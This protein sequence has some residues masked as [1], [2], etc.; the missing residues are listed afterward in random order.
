MATDTMLFL[1]LDIGTSGCRGVVIDQQLNVYA[2]NEVALP[3]AEGDGACREQNPE[4]WWQAVQQVLGALTVNVD[5][6]DLVGVAVD[7]TSGTLL[8]A[9][10]AGVP[11]TPALM[12]NDGR[13]IAEAERIRNVAPPESGAHGPTSALAKLLWLQSR[14]GAAGARYALTQADWI[15]GRLRGVYGL[16]DENN[17]LKLGY[18]VV[19]R[20]W[21]EWFYRLGVNTAWLP[22]VLPAGR[23][24]GPISARLAQNFGIRPDCMVIAGTTDSIAAVLASGARLPGEAVTS[25]GSSLVLKIVAERPIFGPKYGVYSHRVG[26]LWLAGGASNSGGAVLL[27]HFSRQGITDLTPQLRPDEPTGLEY[28]PLPAPSERFPINDPQLQPRLTP[29]PPDNAMFLQ[30]IM[31]GIARIERQGYEMLANLGASYP[32]LVYTAGGGARNDAWRRIRER[33]LGVPVIAARQQNAAFGVA[34]LAAR[35]E[36]GLMDSVDA[37]PAN[38]MAPARP[39]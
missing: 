2:E 34:L 27:Q 3:S 30:G 1:G 8:L 38:A 35:G 18:D 20:V 37:H 11:V 32:T 36:S 14:A 22:D 31:E 33:E 39:G 15:A 21:P 19:N 12:Y 7:G 26:R 13:A 5:C 6:R 29:R 28:Y 4:A 10:E 24:M 23:V 17:A 25:L 16:S 9:D